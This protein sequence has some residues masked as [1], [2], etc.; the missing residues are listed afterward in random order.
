MVSD[1]RRERHESDSRL[2]VNFHSCCLF[3]WQFKEYFVKS[4]IHLRFPF[5]VVPIKDVAVELAMEIN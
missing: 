2:G 5:K 1:P 4:K 3:Q